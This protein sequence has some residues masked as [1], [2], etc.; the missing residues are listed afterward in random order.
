VDAVVVATPDHWHALA[1]ILAV[2][3]GKDVYVEKPHSYCIWES[4]MMVEAA[5]KYSRIVQVGSQN[6]SAPYNTAAAEYVK[7]G[8][9][10][11]IGLVKVYNL[12][13]GGP[14]KLGETEPIP[15]GFDWD[16]WLG[17][18]PERPYHSQIFNGDWHKFW[19][20]SG[21]DLVDDGIHQLD[22]ALMALGDPGLPTRVTCIGGRKVYR[23][24]RE[25]PDVQE[26]SYEFNDR[27]MTFELTNYPRYMEKT[28]ATLFRKD[29]LPY[30]TQNATRIELYGSEQ[31]MM[32]GR[33]GG[34]WQ[35][36]IAGGRIAEQ[37]FGQIV[38]P[39]HYVNFLKCVKDRSRPNADVAI[40]HNACLM[41]HMANIAH[42]VGNASL[43][44]DTA[45]ERFV[46]HPEANA[47]IKRKYRKG[48]EP[49]EKI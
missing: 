1:S 38:D 7:S 3:A 34:G 46:D 27:I 30:W 23:D 18:A 21:G 11:K 13:S 31:M 5:K 44:F 20:Y 17:P 22:L 8:K 24:D 35:V 49:P 41:A 48:Y 28:S 47:W 6:R 36:M 2:Q 33:H 42:R 16:Q 40:A 19:D 39:P 14:F 15:A 29:T 25:V 32:L 45:S 37:M 43:L 4:R 26:V 9:L 12:K 10:G